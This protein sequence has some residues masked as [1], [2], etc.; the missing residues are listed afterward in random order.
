MSFLLLRT[1]PSGIRQD[2]RIRVQKE[3]EES[4]PR[5]VAFAAPHGNARHNP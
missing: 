4:R 1:S 3:R 2:L 5:E